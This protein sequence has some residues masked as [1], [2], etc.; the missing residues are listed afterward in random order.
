MYYRKVSLPLTGTIEWIIRK[1]EKPKLAFHTHRYPM[2]RRDVL[3][4]A[5]I[6]VISAVIAFWGLGDT[7]APQ[8][9]LKFASDTESAVIELHEPTEVS[10]MYYTGLY[11]GYYKLEFSEDG[12]RWRKPS[13]T[14]ED[15]CMEQKYSHL[16]K[17]RKADTGIYSDA[18]KYIRLTASKGNMELG[19]IALYN[20]EGNLIPADKLSCTAPELFDEQDYIPDKPT[21]MSNMYFDEIYHGRTAYETLRNYIPYET[22]HPPLGKH[23]IAAGIKLFGMTPFGWR[24]M[25]TFFGVIMLVIL[26]I[27]LKNIF[28]KTL[29]VS[30]GTLLFSFDFMHFTQTRIATIDTYA[31]FFILLSYF[32]IYRYVTHSPEMKFGKT[33]TPLMLSGL[34][35]GIGCASKWVVVYAG[36]G[37]AVIYA[38]HLVLCYKHYRNNEISGFAVRLIKTLLLSVVFFIIIPAVIYCLSYIP[39]GMAAGMS[40]KDGML[41][42]PNFYKIIWDNQKLMFN[43]HSKLT[44]THSYQSTWWQW[45][46]DIRPI[47]YYRE[48][49]DAGTKSAFAAFGNP[50]VWWG[51]IPAMIAMIVR[52][53]KYRD[54][55]A[56]FIVIGYFSQLGPWLLISRCVFIY[57]YFPS[58]LF[59][60][61][62]LAHVFNTIWERKQRGNKLAVYGY[63]AAAGLLFAAFYPVLAGVPVPLKYTQYFL[64]WIPNMWPF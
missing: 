60:V 13:P 8:S 2:E 19:E 28:G 24:F 53:I 58:V 46:L 36:I 34:F 23:I 64:R 42:N 39:W 41:W 7:S 56:L 45:V 12:E 6:T 37:L 62:A 52:V 21:Y 35:F 50:I 49:L 27:F 32:F 4:L 16:F 31:V 51:G 43:Y 25:G 22:T 59:L 29:I 38:I 15:Y 9:F 5:V 17:W 54:G 3:P 40:V 63:T 44:A 26:Y 20:A 48:Y 18:V 11:T 57:H 47:L 10:I 30:C 1:T 14:T 55:K 33:M 61:L